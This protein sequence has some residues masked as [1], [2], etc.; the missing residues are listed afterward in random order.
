M[1]IVCSVSIPTYKRSAYAIDALQSVIAQ[2]TGFE[3]EILLID[4]ACDPAQQAEVEGIADN[5]SIPIQYIPVPQIGLHNA[6]HAGA[7][8]AKGEI[9]VYVDDDIIADENWL[10]AIIDAFNDPAVHMVGGPCK[11]RYEGDQPEWLDGFW[12]TTKDNKRWCY[13]L[14]LLDYGPMPGEIDPNFIF[15]ANFSIRK[16]T[17][18]RLGGFHPDSV[19]WELRRFRGDGENAIA[20]SARRLGLKAVY[21]PNALVYHRVPQDRMTIE[22]FERRAF[23]EGI[24]A[25]FVEIR[26]NNGIQAARSS[27]YPPGWKIS[28]QLLQ[29]IASR[30]KKSRPMPISEDP[31]QEFKEKVRSAKQAGYEYHQ[32]EVLNDPVLLAWVLKSDYWEGVLPNA[33]VQ[34]LR[35]GTV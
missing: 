9:L 3:Y 32:A 26:N 13:Y 7:K 21:Q 34:P 12:K 18:Y 35:K 33:R 28:Q 5:A 16:E 22:Y 11:P 31:F 8:A 30:F 2:K 1:A 14:S 29:K 27:K 15:G 19:P 10:Q 20:R 25:S 23:L 6:R 4:N 24:S 17:L